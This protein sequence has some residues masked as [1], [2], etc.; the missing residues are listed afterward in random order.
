MGL[1]YM[2][3]QVHIQIYKHYGIESHFEIKGLDFVTVAEYSPAKCTEYCELSHNLN[4]VVGYPLMI[5]FLMLGTGIL[6][7]ICELIFINYQL[8]IRG[9]DGDKRKI[10]T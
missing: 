2:H 7:I 8:K 5:F 9:E 1:G 4:E 10:K 3:E 6:L